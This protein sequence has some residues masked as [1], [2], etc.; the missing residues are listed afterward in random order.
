[1][2]QGLSLPRSLHPC[3]IRKSSGCLCLLCL[4]FPDLLFPLIQVSSSYTTTTATVTTPHSRLPQG[5]EDKLGK[6]PLP[7]EEDIRPEFK[8]DIYDPSYQ[9]EE[10]P[11]PKLQYVWRNIILMALLHIGALYGITLVPSCKFH[12]WLWGKWLPTLLSKPRASPCSG[13]RQALPQ[14]PGSSQPWLCQAFLHWVGN[15]V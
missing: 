8:D 3:R 7:A 11:R 2:S 12:T 9:D 1:M 4:L 13:G 10:G 15:V 5:G 14:S 6:N